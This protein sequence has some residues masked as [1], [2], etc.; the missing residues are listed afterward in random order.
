MTGSRKST[1][2]RITP[3]S[4]AA[5]FE[6]ENERGLSATEGSRDKK[7]ESKQLAGGRITTIEADQGTILFW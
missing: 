7:L 2:G 5:S 1:K 6:S 4:E 3:D